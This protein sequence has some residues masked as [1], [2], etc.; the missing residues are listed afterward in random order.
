[1]NTLDLSDAPGTEIRMDEIREH[2][3]D[4]KIEHGCSQKV[5]QITADAEDSDDSMALLTDVVE[6]SWI[7]EPEEFD[8]FDVMM[9][10]ERGAR[11]REW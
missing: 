1:M 5:C 6:N 3:Q 7:D 9:R 11:R 4:R 8:L 2:H 10:N